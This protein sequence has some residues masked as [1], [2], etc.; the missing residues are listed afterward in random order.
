[1]FEIG[2][3]KEKKKKKSSSGNF[4]GYILR[5]E[6]LRTDVLARTAVPQIADIG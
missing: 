6:H 3:K 5:K 1:M 2:L 4:F